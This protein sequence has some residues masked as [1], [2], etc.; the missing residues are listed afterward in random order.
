MAAQK[1]SAECPLRQAYLF[2][3]AEV[4]RSRHLVTPPTSCVC[5]SSIPDAPPAMPGPAGHARVVWRSGTPSLSVPNGADWP[6][7]WPPGR[8]RVSSIVD[9][10]GCGDRADTIVHIGGTYAVFVAA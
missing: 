5:A 8:P 6:A 9:A 3:V 4:V 7:C 1:L 2:E 10:I